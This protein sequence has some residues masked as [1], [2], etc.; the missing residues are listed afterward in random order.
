VI[1]TQVCAFN[2]RRGHSPGSP[3]FRSSR[4]P[5]AQRGP[6]CVA[7]S[8]WPGA[9]SVALVLQLQCN[10]SCTSAHGTTF[11]ASEPLF[12][13]RLLA[14]KS[15]VLLAPSRAI[16]GANVCVCAPTP[17]SEGADGSWRQTR[18]GEAIC[19]RQQREHYFKHWAAT[20]RRI[21]KSTGGSLVGPNVSCVCLVWAQIDGAF[22]GDLI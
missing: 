21:I 22:A 10:G 15:R 16:V 1:I 4:R 12:H 11:G 19:V 17:A 3:H 18:R 8:L 5:R 14:P 6:V 9:I 13:A 2:G 20:W 7:N